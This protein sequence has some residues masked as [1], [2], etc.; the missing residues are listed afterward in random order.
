[1]TIVMRSLYSRVETSNVEL[2]TIMPRPLGVTKAADVPSEPKP[3]VRTAKRLTA[4]QQAWLDENREA[5]DAH[6]RH[7]EAHG[8][9]FA[10][11]RKF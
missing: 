6:N 3:A 9:P 8:L 4:S 10:Q 7:V 2:E 11:Y 1:M 5:L